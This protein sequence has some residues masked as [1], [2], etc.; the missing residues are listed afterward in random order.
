MTCIFQF[1][2]PLAVQLSNKSMVAV[3]WSVCI[4]WTSVRASHLAAGGWNRSNAS[5]MI[6]KHRREWVWNI[7][8]ERRSGDTSF[9]PL[10]P[11]TGFLHG[12]HGYEAIAAVRHGQQPVLHP[13]AARGRT[14]PPQ[15]AVHVTSSAPLSDGHAGEGSDDGWH[16]V[17]STAG[18]STNP[19]HCSRDCAPRCGSWVSEPAPPL[20]R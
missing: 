4:E 2:L 6:T 9:I 19:K 3:G 12:L 17:P 10:S 20:S 5:N 14:L 7:G 8:R 15:P 16:A 18:M 11:S 1:R 13:P